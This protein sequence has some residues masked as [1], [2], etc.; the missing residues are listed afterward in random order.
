MTR[1]FSAEELAA[2]TGVSVDRLKWFTSIGILKPRE[3]GR[4]RPG[5]PHLIAQVLW[6]SIHGAVALLITMQE[7]HWPHGPASPGL[8][9]F[10]TAHPEL[11]HGTVCVP[12]CGTGHDVR[13]WAKAGFDAVG[14][15]IARG[16]TVPDAIA[17]E[18]LSDVRW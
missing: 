9:D 12:G 14:F 15:D 4:F 5:D 6:A 2:E 18:V 10:L 13:A 17:D 1:T 16:G 8:V 3:P 7:E 11:E